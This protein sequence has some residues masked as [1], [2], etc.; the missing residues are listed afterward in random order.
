MKR[1]WSHPRTTTVLLGVIAALLVLQIAKTLTRRRPQERPRPSES[2]DSA[3]MV[4]SSMKCPEDSLLTLESPNC[5]G[6]RADERR[7]TVRRIVRE[8]RPPREIF[9]SIVERYGED[10]LTEEAARIRRSRVP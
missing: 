6:P 5:R 3:F 9:D 8:K 2:F 1:I 7:E 10:A 4:L